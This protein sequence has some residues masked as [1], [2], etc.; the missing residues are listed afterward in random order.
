MSQISKPI[1]HNSYPLYKYLY[2]NPKLTPLPVNKNALLRYRIIDK[3][4]TN[5]LRR[6]PDM[7][8]IIDCIEEALGCSISDSMFNKDLQQMR[9]IYNAPLEY[10]R[11]HRGYC[12][13]QSGFSIKEFPLTN[14]EIEALDFS[15]ALLQQLKGT[16]MFNHFENAINKVIEGYRISSIVG[17]SEKQ[18]LQVEEPVRADSS[19]FLEPILQAIVQRQALKI[20]YKG[21]G[22]EEKD[23][24]VS[25]Y[26]VKEYRNRWYLI[27]YSSK[28]ENVLVMAFDRIVSL[29][30]AK[31]K[32]TDTPG[33]E[34]EDFFKYSLGI[35]QIHGAKPEQVVLEFT[36]KQAPYIISQ[37]LHHS[38]E[39]ISDND[40]GLRVQLTVYL[41][42]ELRMMILSYGSQV[43]VLEPA[44]LK[45][46]IA[47]EIG[48]M[49]KRHRA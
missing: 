46:E 26:L 14:E 20:I 38:Q 6:F 49:G 32:Y 4:L 13:T 15:T 7:R 21:F 47:A 28:A 16:R 3:C 24:T 45:K 29:K 10:N 44:S 2:F 40:K 39:T 34:P 18:L 22:R 48:R 19:M 23:H 8:Y 35:T 30:K 36:A 43:R 17:R 37:P 5:S 25:P 33:F 27:G 31:E 41:T 1:S 12:Y 11:E 42:A 9:Q